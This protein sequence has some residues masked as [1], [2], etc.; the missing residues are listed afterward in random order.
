[1]IN[2]TKEEFLDN[3]WNQYLLLEDKVKALELYIYFCK[4][5][6]SVNS[7]E[8]MNLLL[9]V[10]SELDTFFKI[11]WNDKSEDIV[12]YRKSIESKPEY[13]DIF[14]ESVNII[15]RDINIKPFYRIC[16]RDY[17]YWWKGYNKVKH[18]RVIYFRKAN[19]DK[20]LNSLAALYIL[21]VYY[22]KNNFCL[23]DGD[24]NMPEMKSN[25]FELTLLKPN[26]VNVGGMIGLIT[27]EWDE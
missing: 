7:Y 12:K 21:E 1:M 11:V 23:T 4:R 16:E 24:T 25:F 13:N 27:D 19:L 14:N 9:S 26:F 3:Y 20:L 15:G 18:N 5:N 8:I 2:L 6:L 10:C 17:F 22:Y